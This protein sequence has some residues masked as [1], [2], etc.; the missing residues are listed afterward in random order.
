M[1]AATEERADGDVRGQVRGVEH[2]RRE[3]VG[4]QRGGIHDDP[5]NGGKDHDPGC[6]VVDVDDPHR[7]PERVEEDRPVVVV[8]LDPVAGPTA[9][10]S[11]PSASCP[12]PSRGPSTIAV[13][14]ADREL[15][16]DLEFGLERAELG[17]V[18]HVDRARQE[19]DVVLGRRLRLHLNRLRLLGEFDVLLGRLHRVG[20]QQSGSAARPSKPTTGRTGRLPSAS[21]EP[22]VSRLHS[23]SRRGPACVSGPAAPGRIGAPGTRFLGTCCIRARLGRLAGWSATTAARGVSAFGT[24]IFGASGLRRSDLGH[25]DLRRVNLGRPPWAHPPAVC[26][27][28]VLPV[29]AHPPS[30]RRPWAHR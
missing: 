26:S 11:C 9:G 21:P 28:W 3:A 10:P 24:S 7:G 27:L 17:L 2:D 30:A 5:P 14:V 19:V 18:L 13:A 25:I 23:V 6:V 20:L 1:Y 12:S 15:R 16:S 8:V 22:A 4:G 29:S